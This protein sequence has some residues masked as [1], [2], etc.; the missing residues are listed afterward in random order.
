M[1]AILETEQQPSITHYPLAKW[2]ELKAAYIRGEGTLISICER[3]GFNYSTAKTKSCHEKWEKKR[4]AWVARQDTKLEHQ[5]APEPI[6]ER[7]QAIP[8]AQPNLD[9][10]TTR[11]QLDAVNDAIMKAFI[12]R[13]IADLTKAKKELEASLYFHRHGHLPSTKPTPKRREN[14][15][16]VEILPMPSQADSPASTPLNDPNEPNG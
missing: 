11:K 12:P 5:N 16:L 3:L 7:L 13:D 9:A 6:L 4:Q 2:L 8:E 1:E 14:R 15:Q 10:E